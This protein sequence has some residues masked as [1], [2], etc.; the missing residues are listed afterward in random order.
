MPAARGHPCCGECRACARLQDNRSAGR[1]PC[2][3]EHPNLRNHLVWPK[4]SRGTPPLVGVSSGNCSRS[5]S[6]RAACA[7]TV[8]RT[9]DSGQPTATGVAVGAYFGGPAL[10]ATAVMSG[11]TC[12]A[13]SM[14]TAGIAETLSVMPAT[15]A[16]T[17][18]PPA[19]KPS[20]ALAAAA[21][22]GSGRGRCRWGWHRGG[23]Y[24]ARWVDRL[25]FP[26]TGPAPLGDLHP[27]G[28]ERRLITTRREIPC[29]SRSVGAR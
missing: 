23:W 8:C 14:A 9:V 5:R 15:L 24:T 4:T 28:A 3:G 12:A 27:P 22:T 10:P 26:P 13:E 17:M 18:S 2:Q 6:D 7:T 25:L 21:A 1:R 29:L 19:V 16:V 20:T 11:R